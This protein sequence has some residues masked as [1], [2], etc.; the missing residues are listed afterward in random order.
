[1]IKN[2]YSKCYKILNISYLPK[3]PRQTVQTQIT[4][5]EEA[6]WSGS[7]LFA[8]LIH[9]LLFPA[10]IAIISLENRKRK[11]FEILEHLPDSKNFDYL[12]LY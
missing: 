8:V 9:I 11:V 3:R 5:S 2:I 7:S 10:L 4:A 1:M 12:Y 6:V